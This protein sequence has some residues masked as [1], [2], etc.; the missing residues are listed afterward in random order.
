MSDKKPRIVICAGEVS[1]DMLGGK[2]A[3]A[4]LSL[5]PACE[6]TG[7][8]STHMQKAGVNTIIN[9]DHLAVIGLWEILTHWRAIKNAFQQI[10]A[11][12]KK[13]KPDLL[14]L[15]DYPGF[16][17]RLA[18]KAK[19]LGIKVMFYVSPQIWAWRYGRIHHIREN[20]DQMAVLFPFEEAIYKKENVPVAC[21]GHPLVESLHASQSKAEFCAAYHLDAS[22]PIVALLPGSRQREVR[23][24]M[25]VICEAVTRIA[26][27]VPQ[28]QFVLAKAASISDALLAPFL[29]APITVVENGTYD[30]LGAS[31]AAITSSGTATLEIALMQVP[32]AIIYKI[33]WLTYLMAKCVVKVKHIGLCNIVAEKCIAKEFVQGNMRADFIANEVIALLTQTPYRNQVIADLSALKS[34]MNMPDAAKKAATLAL[35]LL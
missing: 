3:T 16:N 26:K 32:M 10:V 7:I 31:D 21:V 14:I 23:Q 18:K 4:L 34:S 35:Q 5:N 15:I 20:V 33:N 6:L 19:Q 22:K 25:P 2:L 12:L 9:S 17:L 1:G 13:T 24:F 28:A 29:K 8:G 30:L 11:H 27:Q